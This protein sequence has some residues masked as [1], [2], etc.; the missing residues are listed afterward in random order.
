M[1]RAD[2]ARITATL[3]RACNGDFQLGEDAFQEAVI[4]A[5]EHWPSDGVPA[6]P[7]AWLI[8]TGR[9]KAIDRLRRDQT[10]RRKQ[11]ILGGLLEIERESPSE[12]YPEGPVDDDRLRLIFTC[13]HPAL[14]PEAQVALTLR[15]V[16]G[17]ETH[18]IARG[19]L[20][21]TDTMAKRLVRAKRKIRDARIPFEVPD[22]HQLPERLATALAV[23]YLVFNEGYSATGGDDL[24]QP[25]LCNEAIRL[26]R[27]CAELMPDEPEVL[28]LLA[29]MLLIDA[30]REARVDANGELVTLDE[31]DRS[32][33]D[34]A[35]IDGGVAILDR[36]LRL[37]RTGPFQVQAAIAAL[38][39]EPMRPEDADWR[40]IA[41]L[42][43][44]LL[45]FQPDPVVEL[46]R[47]AAVAMA[48]GP[49]AGLRLIDSLAARD[50]LTEYHLLHAARAD[51]LRRAGR[52]G[53]ATAAYRQALALTSNAVERRYLMRRVGEISQS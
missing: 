23:I 9:R 39:A 43:G 27:L 26:G 4:A 33:W 42:Y 12:P 21:S 30:R 37:R 31:Q 18:E 14:A 8:T 45:Q 25:G 50:V 32:L 19:F 17:L 22:R 20:T 47:A 49:E 16:A 13:C 34:R 38:H 10:L 11:E 24:L 41:L 48:F 1:V 7:A 35:R 44:R 46:N 53:E 36:A 28:G 29:L 15:T 5:L 40:Q 3:I 52:R 51:L 6:Q 2:S